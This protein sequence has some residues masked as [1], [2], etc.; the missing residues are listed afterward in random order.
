MRVLLV[1]EPFTDLFWKHR[2]RDGTGKPLI[3][4]YGHQFFPE[5]LIAALGGDGLNLIVGGN[6]DWQTKGID[7]LTPTACIYARQMIGFFEAL[8]TGSIDLPKPAAVIQTNFCSG[9]YHSLEAVNRYL[10]IQAFKML[11]P[12]RSTPHAFKYLVA[13][14]NT[15]VQDVT[16][17]TGVEYDPEL[18]MKAVEQERQLSSLLG[19]Y[20]RLDLV[21]SERLQG[22]FE[23][24]LAPWEQKLDVAAAIIEEGNQSIQGKEAP[25]SVVVLTGSPVLVGD[26]FSSVLDGVGLPVRFYDY[27]FADQQAMRAIPRE[28]ED[29]KVLKAQVDFSDPI[30]VLA[31]Y[32][33]DSL[34]PERMVGGAM[35]HLEQRVQQVLGYSTFLPGERPLSGV[36]SMV[37]KFCDV[38]GTDRAAFKTLLQ[39]K[40]HVPVLDIERDYSASSIGQ[41]STRIEAFNEM[42]VAD[43]H[44]SE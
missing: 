13:S 1:L 3:A 19:Q 39:D 12:Y 14:L 25:R 28:Q 18:L 43:R 27:Y 44:E 30:Q 15:F 11:V 34:A 8:D 10:G 24:A 35:N 23:I 4:G 22:Y 26:R 32:Y 17:V 31:A 16:T 36:V 20:A 7:Y 40:H 29:L 33:L 21:G 41:I 6:E 9:D 5:V 42:L 38:F 2:K 37:L